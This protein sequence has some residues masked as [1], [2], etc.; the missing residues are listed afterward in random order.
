MQYFCFTLRIL[1]LSFFYFIALE[2]SRK[3]LAVSKC[4]KYLCNFFWDVFVAKYIL[5]LKN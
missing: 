1:K 4:A 3:Q 2:H 5:F